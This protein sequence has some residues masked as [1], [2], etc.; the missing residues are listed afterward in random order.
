MG[1]RRSRNKTLREVTKGSEEKGE[2]DGTPHH[3]TQEL[4]K[5]VH[6]LQLTMPTLK[7]HTAPYL[8]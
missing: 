2:E 5:D 7:L 3:K 6:L 8:Y 4:L 1:R